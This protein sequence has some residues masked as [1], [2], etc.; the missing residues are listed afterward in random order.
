M[1]LICMTCGEK[2]DER[3]CVETEVKVDDMYDRPSK[4]EIHLACPFCGDTTGMDEDVEPGN[5]SEVAEDE[6]SS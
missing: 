4:T 6:N 2:F 3:K 5:L 1:K